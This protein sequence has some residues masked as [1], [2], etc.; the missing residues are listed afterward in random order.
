MA[1]SEGFRLDKGH[2]YGNGR[3]RRWPMPASNS[4]AYL[5]DGLSSAGG[6]VTPQ[7]I[8]S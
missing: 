1:D 5:S 2:S 8:E 3:R 7:E 4:Y 6:L